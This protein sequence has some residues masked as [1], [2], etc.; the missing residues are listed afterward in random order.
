M[1]RRDGLLPCQP[2]SGA[3]YV[4]LLLVFRFPDGDGDSSQVDSPDLDSLI[5]P[6]WR[7]RVSPTPNCPPNHPMARAFGVVGDSFPEWHTQLTAER[8]ASGSSTLR[9]WGSCFCLS[10]VPASQRTPTL[11]RLFIARFAALATLARRTHSSS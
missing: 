7:T 9:K 2:G 1:F 3:V 4:M 10:I 8:L 11:H 6:T 5:F